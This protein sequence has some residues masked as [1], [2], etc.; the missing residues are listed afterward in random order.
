LLALC[1]GLVLAGAAL[2]PAGAALVPAG[3]ALA[4]IPAPPPRPPEFGK[5]APAETPPEQNPTAPK[6]AP[7]APAAPQTPPSD[8]TPIDVDVNQLQPFNLPPASRERMHQCGDEWRKLKMT[9]QSRGLIW[10]GFAEKC[11]AR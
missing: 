8:R 9:G 5:P 1:A 6:S 11:L 4:A 7:T 2:V 10:R 3:A